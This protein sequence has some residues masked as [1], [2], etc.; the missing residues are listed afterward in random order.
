LEF[1]TGPNESVVRA[2]EDGWHAV[3]HGEK[4]EWYSKA[5]R[6][7]FFMKLVLTSQRLVFLKDNK[8]DFEIPLANIIKA[9]YKA[10]M[11]IGTAYIKLMLSNGGI[12]HIVF[13]SMTGMVLTSMGLDSE[14][15]IGRGI[16]KQWI[17]AINNQAAAARLNYAHGQN[18]MAPPPP[19]APVGQTCP[20]C[21]E[22]LT[23]LPEE[24][25]WFCYRCERYA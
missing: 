22:E 3:R 20:R 13:E 8:V 10:Y 17:E 1:G 14:M 11:R 15:E 18:W 21:G 12:M 16:N 19:P 9:E 2:L 5:Y 6:S 25:R 23:F 4:V 7:K 24:G